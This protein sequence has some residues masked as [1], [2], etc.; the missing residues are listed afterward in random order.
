MQ[1]CL[2]AVDGG[3]G[4]VVY[5]IDYVVTCGAIGLNC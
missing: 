4:I 5:W 3:I 2:A 1:I